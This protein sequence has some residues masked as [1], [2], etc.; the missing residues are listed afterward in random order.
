[1]VFSEMSSNAALH[2]VYPDRVVVWHA[3]RD[4]GGET[5]S[6]PAGV[7]V[8]S[9]ATSVTGNPKRRYFALFCA[10]DEP[11]VLSPSAIV[12]FGSLRNITTGNPVGAQQTTAVVAMDPG[13]PS[14]RQYAASL[15]VRLVPPYYAEMLLPTVLSAEDVRRIHTAAAAGDPTAWSAMVR[16]V[17][18]HES[19]G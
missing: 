11:L 14:G 18:G 19:A 12:D 13:G 15:V 17:R 8:V 4:M 9:R 2:D 5:R 10:S 3:Y 1:V 6:L 7:L 16:A